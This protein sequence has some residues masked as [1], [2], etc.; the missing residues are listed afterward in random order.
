MRF[1]VGVFIVN[2]SMDMTYKIVGYA[3][4]ELLLF[5]LVQ[6]HASQFYV[7]VDGSKITEKILRNIVFFLL[8][9]YAYT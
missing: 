9:H 8:H 7:D 5:L 4:P 1:C 2:Y 3:S 6:V